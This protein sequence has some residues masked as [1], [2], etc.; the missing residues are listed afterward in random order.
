MLHC[1]TVLTKLRLVPIRTASRQPKPHAHAPDIRVMS[2]HEDKKS[3]AV[4]TAMEEVQALI[5]AVTNADAE[6]VRAAAKVGT[7]QP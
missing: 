2:S 7:P 5:N 1:L 3:G 4:L 6:G